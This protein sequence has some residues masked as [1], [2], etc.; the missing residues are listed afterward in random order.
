MDSKISVQRTEEKNTSWTGEGTH[1]LGSHEVD[2]FGN[3]AA[4]SSAPN[5]SQK[6]ARQIKTATDPLTEQLEKLCDL[7]KEL[8]WDTSR[9]S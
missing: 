1:S 2:F 4:S 5:T 7:V 8:Q 9:H 3:A 6:V